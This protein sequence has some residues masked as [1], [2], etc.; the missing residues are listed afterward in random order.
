[1]CVLWYIITLSNLLKKCLKMR[2][3]VFLSFIVCS[4]FLT[5][6]DGDNNFTPIKEGV[7]WNLVQNVKWEGAPGRKLNL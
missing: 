2:L 3:S 5:G 7:H 1:M 6:C 4:M